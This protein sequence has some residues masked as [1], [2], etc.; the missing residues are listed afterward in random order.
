MC[1]Q[2]TVSCSVHVWCEKS[3]VYAI[4]NTMRPACSG[5]VCREPNGCG[6]SRGGLMFLSV[7]PPLNSCRHLRV[8][9]APVALVPSAKTGFQLYSAFA[10]LLRIPSGLQ[11]AT[12]SRPSSTSVTSLTKG[13]LLGDHHIEL[14]RYRATPVFAEASHANLLTEVQRVRGV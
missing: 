8:D 14:S 3:V 10:A 1:K 2:C 5:P 9:C 7:D 11:S 4:S 12:L 13:L 6:I